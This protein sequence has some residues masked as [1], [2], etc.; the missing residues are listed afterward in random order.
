MRKFLAAL[1][2]TLMLV[3]VVVPVAAA[4]E[5]VIRSDFDGTTEEYSNNVNLSLVVTEMMSNSTNSMGWQGDQKAAHKDAFTYLEVYN[6]GLEPIDLTD[7]AIVSYANT[8]SIDDAG[9]VT[10]EYYQGTFE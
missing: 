8:R 4:D 10:H 9:K 2:A 1:L 6:R 7:I 3:A 5:D